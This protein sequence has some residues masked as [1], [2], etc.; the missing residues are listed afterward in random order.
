MD[1]LERSSLADQRQLLRSMQSN[2]PETAKALK[3]KLATVET[4]AY[5]RPGLLLEIFLGLDRNDLL[6]FLVG[7]PDHIRNMLMSKIP[8]DLAE[9][10]IEQLQSFGAK[11]T[12]AYRMSEMRILG[13]IRQLATAGSINL[14]EINNTIFEDKSSSVPNLSVVPSLVSE[15]KQED[16]VIN[17]AA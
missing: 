13:R 2:H 4:L 6:T 14:L 15:E 7:S 11:D 16:T 12:D 17:L 10:W 5:L 3:M 1:M 9:N 8:S